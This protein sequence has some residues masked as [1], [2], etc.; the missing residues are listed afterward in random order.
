M[1]LSETTQA[2]LKNFATI[3][4]NVVLNE[5]NTIK[6]IAEAKNVMA[7]ATLDQS[8]EKTVGLYN[9]DEFLSV[10]GLVD[11]PDLAFHDDYVTVS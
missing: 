6:T 3:Q 8:F 11:S 7:V 2:V 10:V 5:G 9:L 4:P 1:Q